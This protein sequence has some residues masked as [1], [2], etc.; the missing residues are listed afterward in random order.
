MIIPQLAVRNLLGA[1][2]RTWLNV[3]VLSFAF[4]VIIWTQ[5]LHQ[6]LNDQASQAMIDAELGGGQYWHIN[7]DPYDA[8]SLPDAHEP[9]PSVLQDLIDS[10]RATPI[11]MIQATIYPNGRVYPII[12]KGIDPGQQIL[13]LPTNVL[14]ASQEKLPVL[15]GSRMAKNSGLRVGDNVTL[16]WRDTHGTFDAQDATIVHIMKTAVQSID[17]GQFWIALEKIQNMTAMHH[18]ATLLVLAK[19]ILPVS[20][21]EN[22]HFKDLGFLLKDIRDI[23]RSK[24]VG[25]SILYLILLFLAMLAIFDT[26]IFSIFRR[27]KEMGT[28]MAL[29]MTRLKVIQLF[30]LEGTLHGILAAIVAAIYGLPLLIYFSHNGLQ[31][32]QST[33]SY[34]IA[35]GEKLFPIYSAG[36][37]SGT[38]IL[39]LIVVTIVSFIPT[40]KIV[41]L[42]PT[43]ALRGKMT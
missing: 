18:E 39:V 33:D 21:L 4:V 3:I 27:R 24:T 29:G 32:P 14:A 12:L 16:R 26:Q 40:R 23:A 30:T 9:I 35:I 2:V 36:L 41:K 7:Y 13:Q 8:I 10:S 43:D 6:G 28:L 11:L 19:D 38:A 34:G 42:N 15:I 37:I 17:N 20:K 22:W 31:L 25:S 1:G 5:G